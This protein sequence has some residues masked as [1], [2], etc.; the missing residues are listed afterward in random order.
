MRYLQRRR[1]VDDLIEAAA[2]E[3]G[4]LHLGD[5]TVSAL[6]RADADADDGRFRDRRVEAARL[7][8][9]VDEAGGHAK[10][11]AVRAHVLAEH[12]HF[13]IAAHLFEE[14]LANR[15]QIGNFFRHDAEIHA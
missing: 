11:A 6:R 15:F 2:D 9:L 3:I 13:R 10:R 8:E 12:E 1:L 14:R 5:G 4:E 7:A